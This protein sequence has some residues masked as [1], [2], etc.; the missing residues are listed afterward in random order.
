MPDLWTDQKAL[1]NQVMGPSLEVEVP[2][3]LTWEGR[4]EV[5]GLQIDWAAVEIDW[6]GDRVDSLEEGQIDWVGVGTD[7]D[8]VGK[9]GWVMLLL[10]L[11]PL[12]RF[13]MW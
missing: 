12:L 7:L 8:Q 11:T 2:F 9:T 5:A 10:L 6:V 4:E 1:Q 13:L 3:D